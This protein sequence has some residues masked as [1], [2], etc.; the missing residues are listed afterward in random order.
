MPLLNGME[1]YRE[2]RKYSEFSSIAVALFT[3]FRNKRED[4]FWDS[5]NVATF[6]KPVT[7]A[8]LN[9]SIRH[10]LSTYH[11]LSK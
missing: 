9:K 2:I 6:T 8:E 3:T 1:T 4:D 11:L 10:I 7:F 5:E